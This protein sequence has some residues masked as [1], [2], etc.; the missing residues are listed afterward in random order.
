MMDV[1]DHS[2]AAN[3]AWAHATADPAPAPSFVPP[4]ATAAPAP[5]T[6]FV[7]PP[8]TAAPAP[9]PKF[10]P[11]PANIPAGTS[12]D[13]RDHPDTLEY[14]AKIFGQTWCT[15]SHEDILYCALDDWLVEIRDAFIVLSRVVGISPPIK[16]IWAWLLVEKLLSARGPVEFSQTACGDNQFCYVGPPEHAKRMIFRCMLLYISPVSYHSVG[17][18]SLVRAYGEGHNRIRVLR[19]AWVSLVEQG[20]G[21]TDAEAHLLELLQV[22]FTFPAFP[23]RSQYGSKFGPVLAELV[24]GPKI[25]WVEFA[26]HIH[27]ACGVVKFTVSA[28]YK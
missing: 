6:N 4:P 17:A 18:K 27:G 28:S 20:T 11:Q 3:V 16:R 1:E 26:E 8:A 15:E 21:L 13:A 22:I 9:A 7:P 12:I 19:T 5:A 2:T 10:V 23:S 14:F 25:K 24:Y